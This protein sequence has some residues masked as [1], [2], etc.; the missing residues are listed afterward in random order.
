MKRLITWAGKGGLA[1]VLVLG[2]AVLAPMSVQPAL[3]ETK[4]DKAKEPAKDAKGEAKPKDQIILKSGRTVEGYVIEEG[5]R[6]V[7][8]RVVVSG[9]EAVTTYAK[10]D[11]LEIKRGAIAVDAKADDKKALKADDKKGDEKDND[12]ASKDAASAEDEDPDQ[13]R[14]YIVELKGRFGFDVSKTPLEQVFVEA[15]KYFNDAVP[16]SGEMQGKT[17]VDPSKRERNVVVLKLDTMARGDFG[18]VFVAEDIGPVVEDQIVDRGRRVVFWIETAGGASAFLPFISPEIYF[19]SDGKLGG[20]DDLD[21]FD[22]GDHMVNEKLIGAFIGHAQGF[23]I[24]GGHGDAV[25][26]LNAMLRKHFWL[27]VKFEG[28]KPVYLQR[29]L[30]PEDG[31]G[32]TLLSDDGK[33]E[34]ED[35]EALRGNDLFTLEP[36]WAEKLGISKGVA[37]SIDDL[38]FRMG[39]QRNYKAVSGKDNRGQKAQTTWKEGIEEAVRQIA[40]PPGNDNVPVGKLWIKFNETSVNGDFSQRKQARGVRIAILGQIRAIVAR[41]AE[42]FDKEGQFRA[43]IDTRIA[44]ER[45]AA[46]QDARA[47]RRGSSGGDTGGGGGGGGGNDGIR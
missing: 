3:A 33:G 40:P 34:N 14:L 21:K 46:E 1:A 20:I 42:V 24:K 22:S 4:T 36:D 41:Y 44:A 27:F 47:N 43:D 11:I 37:D 7:K 15:D 8:V 32:W 39:V 2:L 5:A 12:S 31:D 6:E 45:L 28:G 29:E 26:V 23:T 38:A 25:P 9:I 17:V 18:S 13:T 35:K 19:T 10:S 30:K 16:G